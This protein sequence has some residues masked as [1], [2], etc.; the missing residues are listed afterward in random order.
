VVFLEGYPDR[1]LWW[2]NLHK[3]AELYDTAGRSLIPRDVFI[4]AMDDMQRYSTI[5]RIIYLIDGK[6]GLFDE[7]LQPLVLPQYS[8][9]RRLDSLRYFARLAD[10]TGVVIDRGGSVIDSVPYFDM[11]PSM[12]DY[13]VG[14][15]RTGGRMTTRIYFDPN[16]P[17]LDACE[18][19]LVET[20]RS[21]LHWLDDEL[22]AVDQ[23]DFISLY[24]RGDYVFGSFAVDNDTIT[25]LYRDESLVGVLPY[26]KRCQIVGPFITCTN[27]YDLENIYDVIDT[28]GNVLLSDVRTFRDQPWRKSS[29]KYYY[30]WYQG[31]T[32]VV[33]SMMT[34]IQTLSD[35]YHLEHRFASFYKY[36]NGTSSGYELLVDVETGDR[37][38]DQPLAKSRNDHWYEAWKTEDDKIIACH[39]ETMV[40]YAD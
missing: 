22:Q 33:D 17:D 7:Y 30:Y 36:S 25:H 9:L 18:G 38:Y 23:Y 35:E 10:S 27:T 12:S 3:Y 40:L 14:V 1:P 13:F 26:Y 39:P 4:V 5:D 34:V 29:H 11:Y 15:E 21:H 2:C 20:D 6:Y 31:Q 16:D 24:R 28:M 19:K 8:Y 32:V 37:Y